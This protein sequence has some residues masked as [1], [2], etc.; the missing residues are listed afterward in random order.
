EL[1][2]ENSTRETE[3][4]ELIA[5]KE[6]LMVQHDVLKLQVRRLQSILRAG[7]DELSGLENKQF[8]LETTYIEKGMQ[9]QAHQEILLAELKN[10][11]EERRRLAIK[12]NEKKEK[13]N[14]MKKK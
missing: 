3:L 14:K 9:I 6:D 7:A 5:I 1:E 8:Q 10:V 2:L 11:E 13:I 4:K 12:L